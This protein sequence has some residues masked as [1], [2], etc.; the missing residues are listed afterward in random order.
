MSFVSQQQLTG[1]SNLWRCRDIGINGRQ[2]QRKEAG[3]VV[4]G[5]RS[6]SD[7]LRSAAPVQCYAAAVDTMKLTVVVALPPM[8]SV[9]TV[10]APGT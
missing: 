2:Q 1:L 4:P 5:L 7:R 8:F 6:G 3:S 9:A 10:L